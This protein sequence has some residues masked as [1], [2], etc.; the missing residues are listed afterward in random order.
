MSS[1]TRQRACLAHSAVNTAS[2]CQF[3]SS[4]AEA[5]LSSR[6]PTSSI[7]CGRSLDGLVMVF[8]RGQ[9][10]ARCVRCELVQQVAKPLGFRFSVAPER[11]ISVR[12]GPP[13]PIAL[14]TG[15]GVIVVFYFP[16]I[17][18]FPR[19]SLSCNCCARFNVAWLSAC[20]SGV[21]RSPRQW[22]P[23]VMA[24][25]SCQPQSWHMGNPVYCASSSCSVMPFAYGSEYGF[26]ALGGGGIQQR[27]AP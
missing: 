11:L 18:H 24:V 6:L 13:F 22:Q 1:R 7:R 21:A 20:I 23:S 8:R 3:S 26:G 12:N 17:A 25:P 14:V 10:G 19:I 15:A 4:S 9:S 5:D 27:E 16:T 2:L